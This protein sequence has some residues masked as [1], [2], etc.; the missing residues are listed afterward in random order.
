MTTEAKETLEAN[1]A[2]AKI[3][4]QHVRKSFRIKRNLT[5]LK[6][7][8]QP[9]SA[10]QDINLGVKPGEFMVIVGPSGCGKSTLLDLLAGLTKPNSGQILIDG[11]PITG[12]N[13][14]RGIVF[15]QYALF[16]WK[17]ALANVEF[18]LEAKG[19]PRKQRGEIARKYIHLVGL[20]GFEHRYPHE[21]SGGM[22]QRIAIARSLAYDP[23]VLLMDEPFA[24]LDAQTRETLQSELLRIWEATKKTIIFI[25]HG[26]EEAVYL[27]QRVAVMTSRPGRIKE[28]IEVPFE[29]RTTEEDLRS[30][31]EFVRIRHQIWDLLKDE[32]SRAQEQE[33]SK[34]LTAPGKKTA[35]KGAGIDG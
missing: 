10:L 35:G 16:P 11:K 12:P 1:L 15:Q 24:A 4:L 5:H 32:V 23:E 21:L 8:H 31:P 3:S 7:D 30:N 28:I 13:L 2:I 17:T 25:T 9:V 20:A 33:K 6:E 19:V 27:G 34:S 26:I 29:S 22:K 14:D 18:G